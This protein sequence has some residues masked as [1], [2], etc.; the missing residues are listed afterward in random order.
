MSNIFSPTSH[1]SPY[2]F[3]LVVPLCIIAFITH[4]LAKHQRK[5]QS[6]LSLRYDDSHEDQAN[7]AVNVD[8]KTALKNRLSELRSVAAINGNPVTGTPALGPTHTANG[9]KIWE[10]DPAYLTC[11]PDLTRIAQESKPEEVERMKLDKVLYWK[12]QNLEDHPD[13]IDEARKR[14]LDLFNL[15]LS[16]AA[17]E[18][19]ST[20]LSITP[21]T[22]TSL[23]A[24][25]NKAHMSSTSRYEAY[26]T[27][28]KQ[29]GP[30]EMFPT[31]QYATEWLRL[32]GVVKY[33]DGGWLSGV[34]D[35]ASG[36]SAGL[37]KSGAQDNESGALERKV[38]K[39][40][41]QVI[42]EE[43]GDGD[44]TKN[45]VYVYERLLESLGTGAIDA[46]GKAVPGF[47]RGFD[48]LPDDQGAPR[49]WQAAIAQQCIGLLASTR[50]FFPEAIG[51][52][53]AYEALPYHL[54]VT[55]RELRELG[56]D[57][58]YF[59]LHVTIDNADS[60]HAAIARVAV[61][62]YLEGI[63]KRD[64]Q[65]AIEKMWRRVQAGYI[66]AEGLPTTPCSPK[67]FALSIGLDGH[68]TWR[69]AKSLTAVA[70]ATDVEKRLVD[71]LGRKA[72]AAEKMHCPSRMTI[73][74]QTIEE[75][76]DP[77]A[78]NAEKG[79][80]FVRALGE[81]KPW[82][83]HGD[84]S[85][86]KLVKELEWGGRMF[87]A[88][89]RAETELVRAWIRS[90]GGDKVDNG[91]DRVKRIIGTYEGFIGEVPSKQWALSEQESADPLIK[92]AVDPL[93]ATTDRSLEEVL[94]RFPTDLKAADIPSTLDELLSETP[95]PE[96]QTLRAVD[97]RKVLPILLISTS[98]LELFPFSP[99]RLATPL[100]SSILRLLR[101]QLGFGALYNVEDIC[102]GMDD[103]G[104]D[105]ETSEDITGIWELAEEAY[106]R[107]GMSL[108]SDIVEV[109]KGA[110]DERVRTLCLELL[111]LR[112][113]PYAAQAHLLGLTLGFAKHLHG[114]RHLTALLTSPD[115]ANDNHSRQILERIVREETAA[116]TDCIEYQIKY[117]QTTEECDDW[118]KGVIAGYRM[119]VTESEWLLR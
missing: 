101:A 62:R 68:R 48:G 6:S 65:E 43:F 37:P 39:M 119:A 28:R 61:E 91:P 88:F 67:E 50:E 112:T 58:Y 81:K 30:R 117:R 44:L 22:S 106:K 70:D 78:W 103:I 118:W 104:H 113:R 111:D 107:Q 17:V 69:L 84:P 102:A 49:C 52:N 115:N 93:R 110:D 114:S 100:G 25:L 11:W 5:R 36:R 90:L 105:L 64:G 73:E 4:S 77:Q 45:H 32:A 95:L 16:E 86:S 98:L 116:V 79:L 53:M 59:A 97:V 34:L 99:T 26:L 35:I 51:F 42:S 21:Y 1:P 54:L 55:S 38:G 2:L 8:E 47:E 46:S 9:K 87:G 56:I 71:L 82:I 96:C 109:L 57:D 63:R 40:A 75:W 33:V 27:R 23:Q 24:F 19:E 74:G 15:T 108:P 18:P 29:G 72:F 60:G 10:N 83:Y 89:S 7:N 92:L 12:L 41:W 31:K 14:L 80:S 13:S 94:R 3:G 20:I 85:R 66:L 76:L